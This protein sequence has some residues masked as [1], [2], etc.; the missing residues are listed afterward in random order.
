VIRTILAELHTIGTIVKPSKRIFAIQEDPDDNRVLE[1]AVEGSA[2]YIISGDTHLLNLR[3][4]KNIRIVSPDEYL[5][6]LYEI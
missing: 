2:K 3:Q 6:I 1:C 4:Y 5:A